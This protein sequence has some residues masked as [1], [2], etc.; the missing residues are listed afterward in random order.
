MDGYLMMKR[1]TKT[2]S[3]LIDRQAA[4]DASVEYLVEYCGGAFDEEM[5]NG[6]KE[7]L[8]VLPSAE[9][10]PELDEWCT[11]CKEYDQERHC[12]PRFRRVI[13]ET[14]ED[15]RQNAQPTIEAEPVIHCKDCIHRDKNY[16]NIGVS[17]YLC[18]VRG[19]LYSENDYCSY[20]KRR[21]D[22]DE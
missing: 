16:I 4:I 20:G 17:K 13:R 22:A 1:M 7:R 15:V 12:C 11:D 10:E 19:G 3:D 9:P 2:M 18:L 8:D 5:Q 21:A 14:V 6:L